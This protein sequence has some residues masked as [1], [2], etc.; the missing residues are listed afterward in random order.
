MSTGDYVN[1]VLDWV[2]WGLSK[3][4]FWV[5]IATV[6]ASVFAVKMRCEGPKRLLSLMIAC[7]LFGGLIVPAW[8]DVMPRIF[9]GNAEVQKEDAKPK[10]Q[11]AEAATKAETAPVAES[12][13]QE[14]SKPKTFKEKVEKKVQAVL[15]MQEASEPKAEE[16]TA[17]ATPPAVSL[18]AQWEEVKR[19]GNTFTILTDAPQGGY[20]AYKILPGQSKPLEGK[21]LS[22]DQAGKVRF[23]KVADGK[24]GS[25]VE[26]EVTAPNASSGKK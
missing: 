23:F 20:W 3:E 11:H 10:E 7:G 25:Y 6:V 9:G 13:R 15:P 12:T 8:K 18:D 2:C 5:A 24:A 1:V 14:A 21:T 16:K 4:W 17:V 19:E 26:F 22:M